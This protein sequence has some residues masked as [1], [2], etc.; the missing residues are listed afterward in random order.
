MLV[1]VL[2]NRKKGHIH[3]LCKILVAKTHSERSSTVL[4]ALHI[5]TRCCEL[6]LSFNNFSDEL[7]QAV[8]S[9]HFTLT[10]K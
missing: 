4:F 6:I 3:H 1:V 2:Y 9:L 10:G 5:L 7:L 8:L